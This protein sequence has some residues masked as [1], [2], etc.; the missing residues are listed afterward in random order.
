MKSYLLY[1]TLIS[2]VFVLNAQ[3]TNRN[4]KSADFDGTN[5]TVEVNDGRYLFKPYSSE[6]IETTFV[7]TNEIFNPNSHAVI[8]TPTIV[9]VNYDEEEN[10]INFST[11]G[12]SITITKQPFQISYYFK[13]ETLI[14]EKQGYFKSPHEPMEMV[15]GNIVND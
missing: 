12:L 1:I 11:S 2:A 15:Q 9:E 5:L 7:P 3:N 14:S 10:I 4:F 8:L 13:G 6:I